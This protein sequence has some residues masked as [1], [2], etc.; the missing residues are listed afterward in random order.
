MIYTIYSKKDATI[1]EGT[2]A[3][4]D[5]DTFYQ[6]TGIDEILEIQKLVSSSTTANT[7]NSR[8]LT[9]FDIDWTKINAGSASKAAHNRIYLNYFTTEVNQIPYSYSLVVHPV[10]QSWSMGIG[11]KGHRPKTLD[12]VSWKNRYG[13]GTNGVLW[14]TA[15]AGLPNPWPGAKGTG[16]NGPT[17]TGGGNWYTKSFSDLVFNHENTDLRFDVTDI[18]LDW[19]SSYYPNNGFIVKRSGSQGAYKAE[20]D[21]LNY[22]TLKFFAENTHTVYP[23]RLEIC[24]KDETHTGTD[25]L[26]DLDMSDTGAVFF[27]LKN[28]RGSYK[29]GGKIRFWTYGR[30][31]YPVKTYGTT[32]AELAIKTISSSLLNYSII[33]VRTNETIIPYD[34]F[35]TRISANSKGNYFEIYSDSLMEEREYKIQLRYRPSENSTDYTYYDIKDTFKVVR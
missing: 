34:H 10:S 7:Y 4:A 14:M 31:K 8:I 20:A 15:S 6:N 32:S 35:F 25:S 30:E 5:I 17:V 23:P 12:G 16:S 1:Y 33:D 28:N 13:D 3:A 9:H 11:R 24:W 22:G 26:E 19:S 27:Y 2:G 21:E 29:R 18:G